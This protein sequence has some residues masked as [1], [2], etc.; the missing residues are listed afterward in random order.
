[1]RDLLTADEICGVMG[2]DLSA[3]VAQELGRAIGSEALVRGD[4]SILVARDG[5]QSSPELR[6]ALA[7]GLRA[8]GL[9]VIDLGTVPTPVLNFAAWQGECA[10]GVM[11]TASQRPAKYNGLQV[12]LGREPLEEKGTAALRA[13]VERGEYASG[14]GEET[15]LEAVADY[16]SH[17]SNEVPLAR[18]MR[19]VLDAGNGV[20]A[21]VAPRLFRALGCEVIAMNCEVDGRFPAHSPDPRRPENL[22]AL[23][24]SVEGQVVD[25]GVA[26]DGDGSRLF[27]VDSQGQIVSPD[28]LLMLLSADILAREPGSDVLF[29]LRG[30]RHIASEIV[31]SGGRPVMGRGGPAHMRARMRE[32]GALLA[33]ETEGRFYLQ[34][35][36]FGFADGLYA[37][38]RV[39]EIL[40]AD[41]RP[42]SE[43]FAELPLGQ[44]TPDLRVDL[45]QGA[46][47][48]LMERLLSH[49]E[50]PADA[51]LTTTDGLRAD[52]EDG[53][54]VVQA[55]PA[56][57]E[58]VFRFEGDDEVALRRIEEL[59]R[60]KLR[61]LD[62]DL[63]LPF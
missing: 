51:K 40:S 17:I 20:T 59:F 6:D 9:R 13:R 22:D 5:R 4:N 41:L 49:P 36:W 11:I 25:L 56:S 10:S 58:L 43:V 63:A 37:C 14:E 54:G 19:I 42:S 12:I 27:V 46:N 62:P 1:M 44:I 24:R 60:A 21:E 39:L 29:D 30:S 52:F 33:G 32:T 47:T 18:H 31:R 28:R 8:A 23:I 7:A 34:E 61:A 53:W 3:E 2:E 50:F 45:P 48:A 35:R 26:F 38:A 55:A 15:S 16:L 57:Q